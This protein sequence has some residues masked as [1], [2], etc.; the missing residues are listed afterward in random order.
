MGSE[1][2]RNMTVEVQVFSIT[3]RDYNE[4]QKN[5][6]SPHLQL[7]P[8]YKERLD[9]EIELFLTDQEVNDLQEKLSVL[10]GTDLLAYDFALYESYYRILI[11]FA[12]NFLRNHKCIFSIKKYYMI[13]NILHKKELNLSIF[14]FLWLIP[15]LSIL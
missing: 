1:K 3:K 9:E 11:F 6:T 7:F 13:S 10:I 14:P 4:L 5:F 8:E 15:H 12:K 2:L